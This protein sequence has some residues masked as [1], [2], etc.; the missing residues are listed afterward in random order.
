[1]NESFKK[2]L[3]I[4]CCFIPISI[5]GYY[6]IQ[7]PQFESWSIYISG[8]IQISGTNQAI[9]TW[10]ETFKPDLNAGQNKTRMIKQGT[11]TI[12]LPSGK[13]T[14]SIQL[15]SN[16]TVVYVKWFP[17][18]SLAT[19]IASY[20]YKLWWMD[21]IKMLRCENWGFDIKARWD[22]W[23]A[24]WLCQMHEYYHK[25]IPKEYYTSRQTQV[26]YCYQKYIGWTKFYWPSRIIKWQKCSDYVEDH[27]TII[28]N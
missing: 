2:V 21:F 4:L 12:K 7:Q 27:F 28:N 16:E 13:G 11:W 8:T 1:M 18:D 10:K 26:E 24:V 3:F 5:G 23:W 20:W 6:M 19:R 15:M 22:N 17:E 9:Q 14:K 25:D